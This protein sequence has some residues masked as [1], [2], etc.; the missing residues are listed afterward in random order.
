M[1]DSRGP[2]PLSLERLSGGGFASLRLRAR[3]CT[4]GV[5]RARWAYLPLA[6]LLLMAATACAPFGQSATPTPTAPPTVP[7]TATAIIPTPAP[8]LGLLPPP[9]TDCP[10]APPL[11]SIT[12]QPEGF[13]EP[14]QMSGQSPVWVPDDFLP[15]G[16]VYVGFPGTPVPYPGTKILW[17]IGPGQN[18]KVTARVSDVRTGELAWWSLSGS[19]T[20]QQPVLIF[21]GIVSSAG[22]AG[23]HVYR[24]GVILT[25]T[26]CYKLDVSW[27]GG[28][29]YT[30]FA[31]GGRTP[32]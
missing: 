5:R 3:G 10:T 24:S 25:H 18:P 21:S 7:P 1:T 15:Q 12:A 31:A 11:K 4:S 13:S 19:S 26:G 2:E 28:E 20:P 9:P 29:W 14:V 8:V 30:I 16:T 32:T 17:E 22:L 27:G 6:T 23:F